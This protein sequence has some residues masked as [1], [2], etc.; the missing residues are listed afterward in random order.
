MP[1]SC[2]DFANNQEGRVEN[3]TGLCHERIDFPRIL[4]V[5]CDADP[6]HAAGMCVIAHN[7]G[8]LALCGRPVPGDIHPTARFAKK[9]A[10]PRLM[11]ERFRPS[12]PT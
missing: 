5:D 11:C 3:V 10:Q 7:F 4:A 9:I 8:M 12:L 1:A 2:I 6:R